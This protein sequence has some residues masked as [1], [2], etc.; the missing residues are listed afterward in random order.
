MRIASRAWSRVGSAPSDARA[1]LEA[2]SAAAVSASAAAGAAIAQ[3]RAERAERAADE[4]TGPQPQRSPVA[5]RNAGPSAAG[6][7]S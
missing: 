4:S 3:L 2:A 5:A 1:A 6:A 7:S